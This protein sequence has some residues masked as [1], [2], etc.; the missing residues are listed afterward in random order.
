[1]PSLD[2]IDNNEKECLAQKETYYYFSD[3]FVF[4]IESNAIFN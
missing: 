4:I 3:F 1:V 2:D